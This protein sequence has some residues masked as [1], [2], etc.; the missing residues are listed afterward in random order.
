MVGGEKKENQTVWSG[1]GQFI[2]ELLH[3]HPQGRDTLENLQHVLLKKP[4]ENHPEDRHIQ[5]TS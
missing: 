3:H 2:L 1:E 5:F 4:R